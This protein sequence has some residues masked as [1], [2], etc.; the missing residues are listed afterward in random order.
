M[1]VWLRV[2][3][4]ERPDKRAKGATAKPPGAR[5]SSRGGS[6][7]RASACSRS[8]ASTGPTS[9]GPTCTRRS[10]SPSSQPGASAALEKHDDVAALFLHDRGGE[11]DLTDSMKI[12]QSDTVQSSLGL[13]GKGINVAVYENGPDDDS[14]L[15]IT[16][17]FSSS[18]TTE[19][20]AR[21]THGIIKN[22][23]PN[24]PHGHAAG[25]NLH[26]ANSMDLDGHHLGGAHARLHGHQPELPSRRRADR[27][28]PVVRRHVQGL[29]R[30]ALALPDDPA[31]GRQRPQHGVRQPQGLQQPHGRQPRRHG[32]RPGQR[33]GR[34]QPR[35]G[36][37]RPRAARAGRQR[38]GRHHGRADLRGHEHG[39]A[40]GRGLH[41]AHAGGQRDAEVLARGLPG[42]PARRA[43][44]RTSPAAR[45]G[46]TAARASTPRTARAPS[47][48]WRPCA[49]RRTAARRGPRERGAA[50]T[51]A[52]CA[53]ATSG[54]ATRR[55]SRGR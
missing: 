51:S 18:P 50:G 47:T 7:R 4:E 11:T 9:P 24:K 12:A 1:A 44:A 8:C 2:P 43:P 26:S 3:A 41:R 40:G 21:H 14:Q 35:V 13:T 37:Q 31:G 42:D 6:P 20:H 39:R 23:E 33:L 16:A 30:P 45:G 38:D 25:C 52:R 46:P 53:P 28:G 19:Q 55:R 29:A 49:S 34:A 5:P 32:G 15:S 22:I 27:L 48:A 36:P 10:S 54:P 17:Q